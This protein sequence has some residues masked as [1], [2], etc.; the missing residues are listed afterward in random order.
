MRQVMVSGQWCKVHLQNVL[1]T[2]YYTPRQFAVTACEV[3]AM[4]TFKNKRSLAAPLFNL[5][6]TYI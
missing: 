4:L 1:F 2:P 3:P 5:K 6:P